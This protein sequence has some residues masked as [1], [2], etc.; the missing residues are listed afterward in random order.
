[1]LNIRG[2]HIDLTGLLVIHS[3]VNP[4]DLIKNLEVNTVSILRCEYGVDKQNVSQLEI[5][6]GT[7]ADKMSPLATTTANSSEDKTVAS[8]TKYL[9][10]V[11]TCTFSGG[12]SYFSYMDLR[13]VADAPQNLRASI[14]AI[15]FSGATKTV[16][17]SLAWDNTFP[18]RNYYLERATSTQGPFELIERLKKWR[19]KASCRTSWTVDSVSYV[20]LYN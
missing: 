6:R 15:H 14:L 20:D 4:L 7:S 18:N 8:N 1:M 5:W 10:K 12:C 16:D 9:Y 3:K 11:R 17:I 13:T 19:S 2:L